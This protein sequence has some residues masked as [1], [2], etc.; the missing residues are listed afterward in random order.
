MSNK[1]I[2]FLFLFSIIIFSYSC[3]PKNNI[4]DTNTITPLV[5]PN[6]MGQVYNTTFSPDDTM[7]VDYFFGSSGVSYPTYEEARINTP[8]QS[9]ITIKNMEYG[10]ATRWEESLLIDKNI[11]PEKLNPVHPNYKIN[12]STI[13]KIW[14]HILEKEYDEIISNL[15]QKNI[16][17]KNELIEIGEILDNQHLSWKLMMK[18]KD[19]D[20]VRYHLYAVPPRFYKNPKLL[21]VLSIEMMIDNAIKANQVQTFDVKFGDMVDSIHFKTVGYH[22][23]H[24]KW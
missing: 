1:K 7:T 15:A 17:N 24:I 18:R 22:P 6:K 14:E 19:K 13:K 10:G 3:S 5:H 21:P 4:E 8:E 16:I 20:N 12:Q 11:L 2:Y 23:K 9:N